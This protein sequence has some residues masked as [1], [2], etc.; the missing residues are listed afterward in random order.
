MP[1]RHPE[2]MLKRT[3]SSQ[4]WVPQ[5]LRILDSSDPQFPLDCFR[6]PVRCPTVY[7]TLIVTRWLVLEELMLIFDMPLDALPD[8]CHVLLGSSICISKA[9]VIP[10]LAEVPLKVLHKVYETWREAPYLVE[11]APPRLLHPHNSRG[12]ACRRNKLQGGSGLLTGRKS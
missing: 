11:L 1:A 12:H 6:L 3:I 9:P 4:I 10:F 8:D 7:G 2:Q 5:G